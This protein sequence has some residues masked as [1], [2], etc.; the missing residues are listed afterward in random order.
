MKRRE[1]RDA[2]LE[3]DWRDRLSVIGLAALAVGVVVRL[4]ANGLDSWPWAVI[5]AAL[6][7]VWV[8][9][10]VRRRR[11]HD[12]RDTGADPEDVPAMERRILKGGAP[13]EDPDRRRE[14]AALVDSRQRRLRRGRKWAFPMLALIFFGTSVLWFAAGS[15]TAGSLTLAL[16]VAFMGW[17]TWFNLRFDRRLTQM[18]HR[19]RT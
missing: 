1:R 6:M 4:A 7:S 5:S 2:A 8:V 19:L 18:R 14:M 13:P 17:L 15:T 11:R 10:L 3:R 9:F 12:A 16:A